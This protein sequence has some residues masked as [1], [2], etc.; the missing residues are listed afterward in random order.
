[1]YGKHKILRFETAVFQ[2]MGPCNLSGWYRG[3]QLGHTASMICEDGP[4]CSSKTL[5]LYTLN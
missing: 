2:V 5:T 1:M 4:E 3:F